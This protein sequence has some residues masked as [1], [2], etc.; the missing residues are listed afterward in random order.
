MEPGV[1]VDLASL[2]SGQGRVNPTSYPRV[3]LPSAL[4]AASYLP[5]ESR[6][7]RVLHLEGLPNRQKR[8]KR[9]PG[10]EIPLQGQLSVQSLDES[11]HYT[12][13]SYVWAQA[14][15]KER[16]V[17]HIQQDGVTIDELEITENCYQ[18]LMSIR[19]RAGSISLWVD[20]ICINQADDDEKCHQVALLGDIYGLATMTYAWL[21]EGHAGTDK[22][23][24]YVRAQGLRS[25]RL[26]LGLAAATTEQTKREERRR[27]TGLFFRDIL[28]WYI[29][30]ND[31]DFI[32]ETVWLTR[33]WTFQEFVLSHNITLLCGNEELR[34][35]E[36]FAAI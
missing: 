9:H 13:L 15:L 8:T 17:I 35:E 27:Y 3:L 1:G 18:A 16:R 30:K 25:T 24:R 11:P 14:E 23:M 28:A 32:L 29:E 10:Q 12:A 4:Y 36:F 2:Q 5:R 26:Q 7:I 21:G 19:Q 34:W 20:A 31:L 22:A 6:S 33:A